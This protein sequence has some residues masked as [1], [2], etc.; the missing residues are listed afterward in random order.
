MRKPVK[1]ML[2]ALLLW[3]SAGCDSE[4]SRQEE[5]PVPESMIQAA[6]EDPRLPE[7]EVKRLDLEHLP[8]HCV[9]A[10]TCGDMVGVDCDSDVDGPYYYVEKPTGRIL[11]YCGGACMAPEPGSPYCRHCPPPGWSC[12]GLTP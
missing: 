11:E 4:P 8:A 1:V 9:V 6:S 2:A 7:G 5:T 12:N 3:G 10:A